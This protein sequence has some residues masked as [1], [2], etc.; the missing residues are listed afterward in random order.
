MEISQT[1]QWAADVQRHFIIYPWLFTA[2][3][4][5]CQSLSITRLMELIWDLRRGISTTMVEE[6]KSEENE[7]ILT[8]CVR[9][10]RKR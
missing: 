4:G 9:N 5:P 3:V 6:R 7:G 1:P 8:P 2:T 10:A